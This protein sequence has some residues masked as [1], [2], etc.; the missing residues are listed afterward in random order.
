MANKLISQLSPGAANVQDTDLIEAQKNGELI[1]KKFTGLQMRAV[2]KAER[3]TQDNVIEASTGL[4][5]DGSF[6]PPATSWGLR[7]VDYALGCVDRAGATG[8]LTQNIL[9]GLRLLDARMFELGNGSLVIAYTGLNSDTTLTNVV[10]AGYML[11]YVV[12]DEKAAASPVLDLGTTAGGNQVFI[13]QAMQT[14]DLTTIGIERTFSLSTATTLYLNDDDGASTWDSSTIDAYFIL[15]PITAGGT[16]LPA[17]G[18][19]EVAYYEADCDCAAPT[20]VIITATIGNA[21]DFIPGS[22][23]YIKD[24][25]GGCPESIYIITTDGTDWYVNAS[26]FDLAT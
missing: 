2:E 4:N 9:N 19:V 24:I 5:A 21:S 16:A 12:I 14:S 18:T 15:R 22:T 6:T 25:D 13:N 7:A 1:T 3:E 23:F 20:D 10:P 8:A 11:E 17:T 26:T